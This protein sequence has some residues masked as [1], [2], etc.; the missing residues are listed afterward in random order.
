[1]DHPSGATASA[2]WLG[3]REDLPVAEE[4]EAAGGADIRADLDARIERRGV[5]DRERLPQLAGRT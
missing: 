1:V 3:G 2:H 5:D 4:L